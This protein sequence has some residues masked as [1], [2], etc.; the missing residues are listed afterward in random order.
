MGTKNAVVTMSG[1]VCD[2]AREA[3]RTSPLYGGEARQ[4]TPEWCAE[5]LCRIGSYASH[6][7]LL[8]KGTQSLEWLEHDHDVLRCDLH[9]IEHPDA[10]FDGCIEYET[11][12][13]LAKAFDKDS[14]QSFMDEALDFIP[15][16]SDRRMALVRKLEQEYAE[17][18]ARTEA[19]LK[20]L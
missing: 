8:S 12:Q 10:V 5:W 17:S 15:I 9:R 7:S 16:G 1:K 20:E 18:R 4:K 13:K 3:E 19:Q 6:L 2:L 14:A 11:I